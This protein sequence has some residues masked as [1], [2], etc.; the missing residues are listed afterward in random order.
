MNALLALR[1]A[2]AILLCA[3]V[4]LSIGMGLRQ[5]L[6]LFM[7]SSV[8]DLG[9]TVSQFTLAI[10][11]QNLS[12][13]FL[14]PLTG[15]LAAR[16]GFR[17]VMMFGGACY[18]AGMLLFGLADGLWAVMA[19]AGLMIGLGLACTG[20]SM[21]MAAAAKAVSPAQRSLVMGL[22][23]AL[24]SLGSLFSAPI[25]Q[26]L[27]VDHGWR[28]GVFGFV[29]LA[30]IMVPAAF[31]AGRVDRVT[32]PPAQRSGADNVSAWTALA[33]AGRQ[34]VYVITALAFF[35]CGLQLVFLT[36]HLPSYLA[37]CGMDPMLSAQ[38]LGVVGGFNV[39]GS[40]F[41]GWAGG[42][43]NKPFLLGLIYLGRSVGLGLYF[44][45][46]PT[47]DSTL[48]MAAVIGFLWLGVAP[49]VTGL[50]AEMFGLRWTAMLSGV[51]FASHQVGSFIG[52]YGGGVLFDLYGNYTL[53]WQLGVGMGVLA[54]LGQL[55]AALPIFP[56]PRAP[57]P[58]VA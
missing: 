40:L 47:T 51:A 39:L 34:P 10:A 16:W 45:L 17:P 32:V 18:T 27:M 21:S 8:Q 35:I 20:S 48:L 30:A 26:V 14:Q 49:L 15:G 31:I 44:F 12:W 3:G 36:T 54:A 42:R 19:G 24:G 4:V 25:G 53:A 52:A 43:W 41:F 38:A 9:I 7:Q 37:L 2:S 58:A 23:S 22:V 56:G 13:G 1:P 50:V 46:P 33:M 11:I 5:S 28:V 55:S 57:K 29:A 6:G